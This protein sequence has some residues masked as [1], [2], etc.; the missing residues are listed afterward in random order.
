M[1]IVVTSGNLGGVMVSRLARNE[2]DVGWIL[3]LGAIFPMFI[4]PSTVFCTEVNHLS[5]VHGAGG[6]M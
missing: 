1:G 6:L 2:R 5:K 4:R 3:A